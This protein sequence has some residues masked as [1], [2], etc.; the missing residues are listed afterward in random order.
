M[1][2]LKFLCVGGAKDNLFAKLLETVGATIDFIPLSEYLEHKAGAYTG[3]LFMAGYFDWDRD[4]K[5]KELILQKIKKFVDNGGSLYSEYIQCPDYLFLHNTFKIKQNYPPRPVALERFLV[6]K[7]HYITDGFD[8]LGILPVRNCTF[9]PGLSKDLD[10][11]ASFAVIRGVHRLEY[12]LPHEWEMF[13]ALCVGREHNEIF[14]TFEL[15]KYRE[16]EFP[17]AS[18][19]ERLLRKIVLYLIPERSRQKAERQISAIPLPKTWKI[20]GKS[21]ATERKQNYRKTL[22]RLMKWYSNSGAMPSPDG[23]SGV[24]EGFRSFD[25]GRLPIIRP[26]CNAQI[27]LLMKLYGHLVKDKYFC[28]TSSNII[29]LRVPSS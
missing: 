8:E 21:P 28:E 14:A 27:A 9:L 20:A 15:S 13:P 11:L 25:H 1:S 7:K 29:N 24:M 2:E 16:L 26:D 12:E 3:M 4:V 22:D 5:D 18:Q 19:W 10:V 6:R 17:L 23:S